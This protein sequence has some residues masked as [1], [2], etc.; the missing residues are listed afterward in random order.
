MYIKLRDT[1]TLN[2][3][4]ASLNGNRVKKTE[5]MPFAIYADFE[6][7]LVPESGK[8]GVMVEHVPSG[9]A[10]TRRRSISNSKRNWHSIPAAIAWT[11]FITILPMSRAELQPF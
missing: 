6:S 4:E 5:R 1:P 11:H 10:L 2:Q 9:F 7:C 3:R 8:V